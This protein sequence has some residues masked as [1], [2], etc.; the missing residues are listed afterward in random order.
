MTPHESHCVE[1]FLKGL[2]RETLEWVFKVGGLELKQSMTHPP[3]S[4]S[5]HVTKRADETDMPWSEPP[6]DRS[7]FTVILIIISHLNMFAKLAQ[8]LVELGNQMSTWLQMMLICD[9]G[10]GLLNCL[11]NTLKELLSV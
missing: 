1:L 4:T 6:F 7:R 8:K 11:P 2:Q 10:T 5:Q 3:L 9:F